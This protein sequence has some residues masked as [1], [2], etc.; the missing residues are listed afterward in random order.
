MKANTPT[1]KFKLST[2][3][4]RNAKDR[5]NQKDESFLSNFEIIS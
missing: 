5:E 2:V 4:Q 3:E 1:K